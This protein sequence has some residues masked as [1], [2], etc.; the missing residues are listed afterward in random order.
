[1]MEPGRKLNTLIEENIFGAELLRR[2][3]GLQFPY[4]DG[5]QR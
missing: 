5:L 4:L 1:V 2:Y 3:Y